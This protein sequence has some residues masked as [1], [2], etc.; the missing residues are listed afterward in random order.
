MTTRLTFPASMFSVVCQRCGSTM[1]K[2]ADSCPTCPAARNAAFGRKD[3]GDVKPARKR[4]SMFEQ[5][6]TQPFASAGA[7]LGLDAASGAG[8]D[9]R[10][11]SWPA[12]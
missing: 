3:E 8:G 9:D 11:P 5:T 7:S 10:E 1:R 4:G 12:P 2:N 6:A